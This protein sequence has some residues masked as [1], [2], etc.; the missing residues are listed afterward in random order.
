M[1]T[2]QQAH[3][4]LYQLSRRSISLAEFEQWLYQTP[5]LED[6]LGQEIYFSFLS[7]NYLEAN[8]LELVVEQVHS[9][10]DLPRFEQE[11]LVTLLQ[12][13]QCVSDD[14]FVQLKEIYES[15]CEGYFFLRFIALSYITAGDEGVISVKRE[16]AQFLVW[17][18]RIQREALRLLGFIERGKLGVTGFQEYTDL[19]KEE[20]R[21]EQNEIEGMF[22]H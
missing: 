20:D 18:A 9:L 19:R 22:K 4:I 2:R 5:E 21:I 13:V 16:D 15:Y 1:V 14:Y 8:A 11:R 3:K 10:I 6:V 7:R 17:S 12:D